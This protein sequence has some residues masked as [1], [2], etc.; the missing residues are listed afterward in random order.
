MP[1]P[2]AA[3]AL[4]VLGF[5]AGVILYGMLL[6]MVAGVRPKVSSRLDGSLLPSG[7]DQLLLAMAVAGL[8]WNA[9]ALWIFGFRERGAGATRWLEVAS[10]SALGLLPAIA[11]H[12]VVRRGPDDRLATGRRLLVASGYGLSFAAALLHG[13]AAL[14]AD[15][16]PSVAALRL[17]MGGFV[18]LMLPLAV[19]TRR[20][21][22]AR[23][24][25]W[26]LAFA[27]FAVSALHLSE[28]QL[29]DRWFI[30]LAGHHGSLLLAFAVLYQ[31]YPFALGDLFL[32][33][34]IAALVLL[35]S[36]V[37]LW[38][39]VEPLVVNPGAG[40]AGTAILLGVWMA[41]VLLFPVVVRW[42]SAL[43]DRLLLRGFDNTSTLAALARDADAVDDEPL[44]LDAACRVLAPALSAL[45]VS[46][47]ADIGQDSSQ[48]P[49]VSVDPRRL[50]ASTRVPTTEPPRF[51]LDVADVAGGRR[52]LSDEVTLL[53]HAGHLVARRL[54]A[55]RLE[56]ER[57][58]RRIREE[59]SHR[60]VAEAKLQ[61][62]RAQI[63]PHFLFNA[64]TTIGYLVQTAPSEA[65]R[66]LLRLTEVLR[67]VLRSDERVV[68][69]EQELRLVRAYLD[70]EQARFEERLEV[71]ID[72]PAEL[73]RVFVPP[74]VLQPLVE[75]AVKHGV[76]PSASGG[77]VRVVARRVIVQN[78]E[79]TLQLDVEDAPHTAER[80]P[81]SDQGSGI[82]LSNIER[83]LE[84]AYGSRAAVT[85]QSGPSGALARVVLPLE[86]ASPAVPYSAKGL[87]S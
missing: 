44:V 24:M 66:T 19:M 79:P 8:V 5:S 1:M 15:V 27:V 22:S 48:S 46:W 36:V 32:K 26:L 50:S 52:L 87:P 61:A 58:S 34:A 6:A 39:I 83:R 68:P 9:G 65:V 73:L 33:R 75:N 30:E 29:Q 45:E 84:L 49:I 54:D 64:L 11:V 10:F 56:R 2:D 12:A 80:M 47:R 78:G 35:L 3:A 59:E 81:I 38:E 51:V 31:D 70:I 28:H 14:S 16:V 57:V 86:L 37:A 72:V 18:V 63:N 85:L 42:T 20:Q 76:S 17:L 40:P 74:L 21:A 60:L 71:Q 82:A 13:W 43:V 53:E 77:R 69:L 67:H 4:H 23:R 7:P 25:L 55:I 41:T 62:L